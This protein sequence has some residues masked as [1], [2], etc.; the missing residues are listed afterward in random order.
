L[1]GLL[2]VKTFKNVINIASKNLI[3]GISDLENSIKKGIMD[4]TAEEI[5]SLPLSVT[6]EN[7]GDDS[8]DWVRHLFQDYMISTT[9]R[10]RRIGAIQFVI[11]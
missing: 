3:P 7:F 2:Y 4:T 10:L 6:E 8:R 11:D 9:D 1:R 5:T